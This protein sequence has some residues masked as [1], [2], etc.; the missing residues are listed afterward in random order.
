MPLLIGVE[1][2][3]DYL[4]A[5]WMFRKVLIETLEFNLRDQFESLVGSIMEIQGR[6]RDL[7]YFAGHHWDLIVGVIDRSRWDIARGQF[8][9]RSEDL[10]KL[11]DPQRSGVG[12]TQDDFCYLISSLAAER[13]AEF[14]P[15]LDSRMVEDLGFDSLQILQLLDVLEQSHPDS[16]LDEEIQ[17][18]KTVRDWYL[19]YLR[20]LQR[21]DV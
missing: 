21:P 15:S 16:L 10:A 17:H 5:N 7:E 13:G 19:M 14:T 20:V 18:L 8:H 11:L 2:F 1:L 4:F 3:L 6:L 9:D 12:L